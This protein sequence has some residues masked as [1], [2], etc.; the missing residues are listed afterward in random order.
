MRAPRLGLAQPMSLL[1]TQRGAKI[2]DP[3]AIVRR[4]GKLAGYA[5]D[6]WFPQPAP[7]RRCAC[8]AARYEKLADRLEQEQARVIFRAGGVL[9]CRPIDFVSKVWQHVLKL[10]WPGP[11]SD[12]DIRRSLQR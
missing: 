9:T 11:G 6:V 3:D 10:S 12:L 4:G 7:S 5:G 8:F 1:L 2:C